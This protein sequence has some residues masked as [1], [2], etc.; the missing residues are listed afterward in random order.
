MSRI[1]EH[2]SPMLACN[3]TGIL[4]ILSHAYLT[5]PKARYG[6]TISSYGERFREHTAH[7]TLAADLAGVLRTVL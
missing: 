6:G 2:Y 4:P 1:P 3:R 5:C 7:L